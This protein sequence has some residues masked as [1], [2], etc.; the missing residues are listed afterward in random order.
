MGAQ[1]RLKIQKEGVQS[2]LS[3][4]FS[5]RRTPGSTHGL[6]LCSKPSVN[7]ASHFRSM[8][9]AKLPKG[10]L[11]HLAWTDKTSIVHMKSKNSQEWFYRWVGKQVG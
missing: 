11:S 2:V 7:C 10:A 3:L 6:P 1:Q 4:Q 8:E 5:S 9:T